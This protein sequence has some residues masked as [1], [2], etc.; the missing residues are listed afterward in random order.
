MAFLPKYF[1]MSDLFPVRNIPFAGVRFSLFVFWLL[2]FPMGGSLMQAYPGSVE[3]ALFLL[4]H[5]L[6]LL[7]VSR[8]RVE[9]V[10]KSQSVAA[11]VAAIITLS[12]LL[13]DPFIWLLPILGVSSA[14]ISLNICNDLIHDASPVTVIAFG[15][16]VGN[17]FLAITMLCKIPLAMHII[18][19]ALAIL[20]LYKQQPSYQSHRSAINLGMYLICLFLF[21]LV[22]G[23]M[24]GYVFPRYLAATPAPGIELAFYIAAIAIAI[25]LKRFSPDILLVNAIGFAMFAFALLLEAKPVSF[26]MGMFSLQAASGFAD[27]F[28]LLLIASA[29]GGLVEL[30][31]ALGSVCSAILIGQYLVSANTVMMPGVAL[32]GNL[33]LSLAVLCLYLF[34]RKT[35]ARFKSENISFLPSELIA[36]RIPDRISCQLSARELYV[37][38]QV[39]RGQTYREIAEQI[40][41]TE[42]TIKTYMKRIREKTGTSTKRELLALLSSTETSVSIK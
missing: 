31:Y 19:I 34:K 24:Y 14:I 29:G 15:L 21:H 39:V 2:S 27:M 18:I 23:L 40:G 4:P 28:V 32:A 11:I 12:L 22:S 13:P 8:Y 3:P 37:L 36:A 20:F 6:T 1:L 38:K 35:E 30:G 5:A 9:L 10:R 26:V 16:I 33:V 7:L 17:I 42:S 41:V 25:G